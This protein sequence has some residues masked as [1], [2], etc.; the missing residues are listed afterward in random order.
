MEVELFPDEEK[1]RIICG[2][3]EAGRGPLAGPVVAAAVILPPDFPFELL[4]DSKKLTEKEREEAEKV[5]RKRPWH[6]Q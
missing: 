3:D 2:T 5:I 1:K 4:N 6:S